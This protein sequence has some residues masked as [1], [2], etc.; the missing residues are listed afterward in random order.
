M[1]SV[2]SFLVG[3]FFIQSGQELEDRTEDIFSEACNI[4]WIS[5]NQSN[6]KSFLIFLTA[7]Q[8]PCR[9][10]FTDEIYANYQL[11]ITVLRNVYSFAAIMA[12][13]KT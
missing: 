2:T 7:A 5:L 11:G 9:L 13:V 6:K 8:T 4:P 1:W 12:N 3:T 10:K